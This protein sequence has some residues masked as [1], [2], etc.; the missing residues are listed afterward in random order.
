[1]T[2]PVILLEKVSRVA[3]FGVRFR[4]TCTGQFV[5]DGLVVEAWAAGRP[6]TRRRAFVT[7]SKVWVLQ[8]LPGL[9]DFELNDGQTLPGAPHKRFT[10]SVRDTLERFLPATFLAELPHPGLFSLDDATGSPLSPP[11]A[12]PSVPLFSAPTRHAPPTLAVLHAELWDASHESPAAGALLEATVGNGPAVRG[13]ADERGRTALFFPYPAPEDFAPG[14][15]S[16]FSPGLP[17]HEQSWTVRLTAAY[18][19][20]ASA[21]ELRETLAQPPAHL[22]HDL[23]GGQA[24]I[25][26]TLHSGQPL[27]VRTQGDALHRLRLTPTGSPL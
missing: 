16:S 10:V 24:L 25:E 23:S 4:D 11:S 7:S 1:M 9:R 22:W 13:M 26:R 5:G 21:P 17:P 6:S 15:G 3:P 8:D 18:A 19:P 20:R 27:V 14:S 2:H 12:E